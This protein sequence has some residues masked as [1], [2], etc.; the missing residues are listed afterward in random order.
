MFEIILIVRTG[1]NLH[2]LKWLFG[3]AFNE[4]LEDVELYKLLLRLCLGFFT[5]ISLG[6]KCL[7]LG[8]L[9]DYV[10]SCTTL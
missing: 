1:S 3:H 10:I 4:D 2:F 9:P 5:I 6:R 7:S 8:Y